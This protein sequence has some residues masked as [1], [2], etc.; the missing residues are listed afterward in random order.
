[1]MWYISLAIAIY[2]GWK[3]SDQR[4]II[5]ES[6]IGYWLGIIGGIMMLLLLVYPLRK[7]NPKLTFLGS[8][9]FWFR[10]HMF[11]GVTG[12]V[13]IIFHSGYRLGSLNG[14]V[15][16]I[17]MLIVASSGLIGRYLYRRIHHG[18]YGEKIQFQDLYQN[19]ENDD[20][21]DFLNGDSHQ[22]LQKIN[23]LES[24]L[25]NRTDLSRRSLAFYLSC[26]WKLRKLVHQLTVEHE[27]S[28]RRQKVLN[29]YKGLQSICNLGINEILFSYW[30]IL[31]LPLFIM[32]VLSGLTH[33]AVVHFY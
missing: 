30:H 32:L 4:Y 24:L 17:S 31:H 16:M 20:D 23:E 2:L 9:K 25:T 7:Q 21:L 19:S 11:L 22:S 33:V 1:M 28:D 15:A 29:R 26:R 10:F 12:P 8:I 27:A 18:L 14:R 6:G 3:V 5:A 13:L